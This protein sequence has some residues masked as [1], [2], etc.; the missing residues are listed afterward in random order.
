MAAPYVILSTFPVL[1]NKL[2]RPGQWMETLKQVLAFPMLGTT[3]WLAWV[4]G[5]QAGVNGLS[6]LLLGLLLFAVAAWIVGRWPSVQVTSSVR[7]VTRGM[8]LVIT[9]MGIW[10]AY[11]GAQ[12]ESMSHADATSD[13]L[14]S[15][16]STEQVQ[17]L[18]REGRPVFVDFTATWCSDLP[19]E[20]ENYTFQQHA[21]IRLR[22]KRCSIDA[23]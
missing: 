17:Q 1:F 4:F 8:A 12:Q 3:V 15:V 19:S 9:C 18:S 13:G 22:P 21:I 2:P 6:L 10:F 14:W 5:N 16:Y 23:G 11:L 7:I 20:Q